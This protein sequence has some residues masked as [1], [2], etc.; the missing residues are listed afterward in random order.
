ME[1]LAESIA[2]K[3]FREDRPVLTDERGRIIDGLHRIACAAYL[4]IRRIPAIVYPE[5]PLYERLLGERNRLPENML[6]EAGLSTA[7]ILY[8]KDA[9]NELFGL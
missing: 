8:L 2:E 9:R 5:S 7:E 3:G 4:H 1:M 6:S